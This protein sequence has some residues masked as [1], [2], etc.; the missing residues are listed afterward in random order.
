MPVTA[1]PYLHVTIPTSDSRLQCLHACNSPP[2]IHIRTPAARLQSLPPCLHACN[3]HPC[4]HASKSSPQTSR[5][6][7]PTPSL[8][9]SISLHQA[10]TAPYL[11]TCIESP[12]LH[13]SNGEIEL[14]E[15]HTSASRDC[16]PA[17]VPRRYTCSTPLDLYTSTSARLLPYLHAS[18][19]EIEPTDCTNT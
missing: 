2:A 10:S 17:E 15:L 4:L 14:P 18:N 11:H 9:T 3:A 6:A 19:S 13:V 12:Y 7:T 8:Q 5:D 16:R 1:P